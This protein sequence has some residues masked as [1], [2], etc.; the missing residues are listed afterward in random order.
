MQFLSE[1]VPTRGVATDIAPGVRRMVAGNP[2][3]MTYHGTN[4]YLLDTDQGVVIVDP[5]PDLPEHLDA[6]LAASGKVAA[7]VATHSH[8][9]HVQGVPRLRAASGAPVFAFGERVNAD[10]RLVE[11]GRLFG[12]QV[13]HT[14]GHIDDHVCLRRDDGV[15]LSGD[16]VMGWSSSVVLPPEGDMADYMTALARLLDEDATIYLPGHGPAITQPHD[17]VRAL[18]AHRLGRERQIIAALSDGL[19]AIPAMV[20]Q[21]YPELAPALHAMAARNVEAHLLKL[22]REARAVRLEGGWA[23]QAANCDPA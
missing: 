17:H 14:P 11:G 3:K 9:D 5:G 22:A 10:E 12:W 7:I 6:L 21:I 23:I 8:A 19:R 20:A 18:L 15:L 2:S 4:T 1:D 13:L 16:H